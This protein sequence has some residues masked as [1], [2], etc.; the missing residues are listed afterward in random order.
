MDVGGGQSAIGMMDQ[1][2]YDVSFWKLSVTRNHRFVG[3]GGPGVDV[4][5]EEEPERPSPQG[6][7]NPVSQLLTT[8]PPRTLVRGDRK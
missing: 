1:W 8:G 7:Q 2:P 6:A 4:N 3:Q 5:P